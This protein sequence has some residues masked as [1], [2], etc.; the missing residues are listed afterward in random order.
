MT[1]EAA[2]TPLTRPEFERLLIDPSFVSRI[3][4]IAN[5]TLRKTMEGGF[6]VYKNGG[7]LKVS[8]A[9]MPDVEKSKERRLAD[10][11]IIPPGIPPRLSYWGAEYNEFQARELIVTKDGDSLRPDVVLLAHSHTQRSSD[12]PRWQYQ[13]LAPSPDD[14]DAYVSLQDKLPGIIFSIFVPSRV[15][16][17]AGVFFWKAE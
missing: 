13:N 16:R 12:N 3:R 10:R 15:L 11:N 9:L 5:F 14:L 2:T 17:E 8:K 6:A 1:K 7:K 4:K